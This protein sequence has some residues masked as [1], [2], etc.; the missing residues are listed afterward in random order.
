MSLRNVRII[1]MK[2]FRDV[3]RD[4]R[5]L[6]FMML[7][8]IA[9]MPLLMIGLTKFMTAQQRSKDERS[10]TIAMD[11]STRNALIALGREWV[12]E[13]RDSWA[14]YKAK[15][16][17]EQEEVASALGA[18]GDS[19]RDTDAEAGEAESAAAAA[20]EQQ[21]LEKLPEFDRHMLAGV[22]DAR[23]V[24]RILELVEFVRLADVEGSG[25]LTSGIEI[26][27]SVPAALNDPRLAVAIQDKE[28]D[29]AFYMPPDALTSMENTDGAVAAWLLH[30]SSITM[31]GE[32]A[33]RM[34]DFI[35]AVGRGRLE[36]RVR[37]AQLPAHFTEPIYVEVAD[38][39][40]PSRKVQ[41]FLGGLLPYMLLAFCF[42]G[43]FYPALDVTAGEKER[44]TLET[45]LLAPASRFEIALG[46]F[47]VVFV[48][49]IVAALLATASMAVTF[50]QGILPADVAAKL[51]LTFEPLALALTASMILP[52]AALY[53]AMLLAVGLFA[54]SFKEA[55]SY[56]MPLQF[57]CVLP[58]MISLIPDLETESYLAWI[59]FVN[60]SLLIKELL[61]GNYLWE[62]YVITIVST[63]LLTIAALFF[64]ATMFKRESVLLRT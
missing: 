43:A 7:L 9:V 15:K 2:D 23:A 39:A 56:A 33:D 22:A 47:S 52:V 38:V 31:S 11:P 40:T 1:A 63:L 4:R 53:A 55:Q 34:D 5:T 16:V 6:I 21:A 29:A 26:P 20:E 25:A 35:R 13:N 61:K 32:T 49:A 45:L 62:F 60:I 44:F 42:G 18:V 14:A 41:A 24:D 30:D 19:L 46:K 28:I 27:E 10:V 54:R 3:L 57:L 37:E 17:L 64:A 51:D 36:V 12:A 59:P 50:T 48:A 8:P 58:S